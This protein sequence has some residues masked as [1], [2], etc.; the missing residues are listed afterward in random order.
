MSTP[1]WTLT[2][3]KKYWDNPDEFRP[4]RWTDP[5]NTDTKEASMPFMLGPRGCSGQALSHTTM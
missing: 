4:E 1:M 5:N 3:S 2:H